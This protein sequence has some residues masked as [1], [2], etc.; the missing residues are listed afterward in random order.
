MSAVLDAALLTL[1]AV[2]A[3]AVWRSRD[4]LAS[5]ILFSIYSLLCAALFTLLDAPD[6]A[7][8]EAAVGAGISAVLMLATMRF[9]GRTERP[10]PRRPPIVAAVVVVVTGAALAWGLGGTP[11]LGALDAP[12]HAHVAPHYL[13]ETPNEVGVPNV[14][15]AVLASYRAFDTLGELAV[16]FTAGVGVLA[17]LFATSDARGRP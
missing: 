8:T 14:V 6:V 13:R 3:I 16:I 15:T 10:H 1:L 11:A 4:L 2:V 9:T 17:L 7:I 12:A 5:V